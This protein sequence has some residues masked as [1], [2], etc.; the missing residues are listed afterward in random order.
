MV[1]ALMP[2]QG[3]KAVRC[4]PIEPSDLA[5]VVN[6]LAEGFP[7]RDRGYWERAL[8]RM[9]DRLVPDGYPRYGLLLV[10]DDRPVGVILLLFSMNPDVATTVRCNVS[11]WYVEPSFRFYAGLLANAALRF[12][13]VSYLNI[14]P[15]T[16]TWPMLEAQGYRR[17]GDGQAFMIPLLSRPEAGVV[18]HAVDAD[19]DRAIDGVSTDMMALLR[20]HASYGCISLV[21]VDRNGAFPF[22]LLPRPTLRRWATAAHLVYCGSMD[23]FRRLAGNIGRHLLRRGIVI[24]A[25]D[26]NAPLPGLVGRYL[27]GKSPRYVRGENPPRLG[28]LSDT[29]LVVFGP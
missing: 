22:V 27:P 10:A 23:D 26:A 28:D 13:N 6:L 21:C 3:V 20:R 12:A 5:A 29:E 8:L 16:N 7:E 25:V 24:A 18:V 1:N 9:R 17:Y 19:C 2:S 14:S 11:S 4:R 15:A